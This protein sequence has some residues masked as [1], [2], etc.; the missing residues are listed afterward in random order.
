[1][2]LKITKSTSLADPSGYYSKQLDIFGVP[3]LGTAAVDDEAMFAAAEI[4]GNMIWN[5]NLLRTNAAYKGEP[6]GTGLTG[7]KIGVIAEGEI[8][9]EMPEYL[10]WKDT[11]TPD[12]RGFQGLRGLGGLPM[13]S[14]GEENLLKF[15]SDPYRG[16]TSIL[17]HEFAHGIELLLPDIQTELKAAF[18]NQRA[19]GLWANTYADTDQYEYFAQLTNVWFNDQDDVAAADGRINQINT[20]IE[21]KDYDKQGYDLIASIHRDDDWTDGKHFGSVNDDVINGTQHGDLIFGRGGDDLITT[22][23][24]NNLVYGDTGH[25]MAVAFAG[26]NMLDGGAGNDFLFGG[27]MADTLIGGSGNDVI[28]GESDNSFTGASDTIIGG[29]GDDVM[30]GG[31]GADQFWFKTNE[32]ADII[33]AF[34]TS[35]VNYSPANGFSVVTNG[36]DFKAGVDQIVLYSFANINADNV[37][38]NF[39]DVAGNAVFAAGGTSITFIG[40]TTAN[41]GADDFVFI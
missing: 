16:E 38:D 40:V 21:L 1:M 41:L 28:R 15:A 7:I 33:G 18:A 25:D 19:E 23:I 37:M 32:G 12:G 10:I 3:I 29:T 14:G 5:N 22:G 9:T 6:D 30:M 34:D 20:R 4:V 11:K 26:V 8:I 24:G 35:A 36:A 31:K 2:S 27:V 13:S 17:L 39:D